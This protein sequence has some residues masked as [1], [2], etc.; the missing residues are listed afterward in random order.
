M[1]VWM[2]LR[3]I[4]AAILLSCLASTVPGQVPAGPV[5]IR[6]VRVFDGERVL[7]HRS[8]IVEGGRISRVGGPDLKARRAEVIDGRGRTLL[9]GL[10]DAHIHVPAN[11]DVA[12]HQ[13]LSLGVT[14][15]LDMFSTPDRLKTLEKFK[16]E[17][18]P[19]AADVRT[20]GIGATA[21]G[22]HPSQMG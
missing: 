11:A 6:D 4:P 5:L 10:F 12:L 8:V 15:V 14:T 9:P 21:P 22:G 16:A 17:D 19:Q 7:E 2:R 20:A 13:A 18:P 1:C 3:L